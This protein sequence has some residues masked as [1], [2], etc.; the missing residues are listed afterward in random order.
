MKTML[1]PD[2]QKV[3]VLPGFEVHQSRQ[4]FLKGER[5]HRKKWRGGP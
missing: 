1:E 3:V 5:V 4:S 2:T